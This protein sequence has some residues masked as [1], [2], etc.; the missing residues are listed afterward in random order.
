MVGVF[1]VERQCHESD[2]EKKDERKRE[3]SRDERR[4]C[5]G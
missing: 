1:L 3:N 5:E 2:D 4:A